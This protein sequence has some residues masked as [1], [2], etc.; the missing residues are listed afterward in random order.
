MTKVQRTTATAIDLFCG[1]GGLTR[2]LLDAGVNVVAGYDSDEACRF[3]YEHN[4]KGTRFYCGSVTVEISTNITRKPQLV[5]S[6][7][8]RPARRF[9]NTRKDSRIATIRNGRC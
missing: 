2:G 4:N 8:V 6:S 3:P 1:A 7:V 9:P 5:F